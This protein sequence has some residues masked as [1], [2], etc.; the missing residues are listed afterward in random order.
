MS[1]LEATLQR[2]QKQNA[3]PGVAGQA[4]D[5]RNYSKTFRLSLAHEMS[6]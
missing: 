6:S 3:Y 2:H 4:T 1:N 5:R